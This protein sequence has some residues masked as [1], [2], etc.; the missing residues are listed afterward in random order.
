M[1]FIQVV[2]G[3]THVFIQLTN[4]ENMLN[5]AFDKAKCVA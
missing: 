4:N 2:L 3:M 5:N 1:V